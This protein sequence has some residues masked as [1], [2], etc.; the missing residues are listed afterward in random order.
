MYFDR[1]GITIVPALLMNVIK[2]SIQIS[3]GKSL[4]LSKYFFIIINFFWGKK[5]IHFGKNRFFF[6]STNNQVV[7]KH[8]NFITIQKHFH[9]KKK[10]FKKTIKKKEIIDF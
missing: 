7:K 5:F 4:K 1:K 3:F 8:N 10:F 2:V 9:F 6:Q